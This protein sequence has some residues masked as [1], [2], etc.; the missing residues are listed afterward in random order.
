MPKKNVTFN[1]LIKENH[2]Q[3]LSTKFASHLT[4]PNIKDLHLGF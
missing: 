3:N 4:T 2:V 1:V